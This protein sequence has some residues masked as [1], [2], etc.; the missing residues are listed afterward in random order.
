MTMG[1]EVELG[2]AEMGVAEVVADDEEDDV[3]VVDILGCWLFVCL[4]KGLVV[5]AVACV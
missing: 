5:N 3:N 4:Q 1:L 2:V